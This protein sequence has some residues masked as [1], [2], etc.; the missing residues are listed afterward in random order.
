[1][2]TVVDAPYD[3]YLDTPNKSIRQNTPRKGVC[4]H[5][6]AMTSL[7]GLEYLTMGAK[8]VS[9]TAIAK[10][11]TS[12]RLMTDAYRAWSLSSA[13]GDSA[14]RSCECA[15]ESTNGWTISDASHWELAYLVAYWAQ[16]DGFWPHR[17]GDPKTWTVVGHREMYTIWGVSYATAC[18]GGMDLDLVT[19]RAQQILTGSGTAAVPE[20]K[21]DVARLRTTQN[22]TAVTIPDGQARRF[23][24][25]KGQPISITG[26]QN[27]RG[28]ITLHVYG[29]GLTE[30]KELDLLLIRG[31][32]NGAGGAESP[33]YTETIRGEAD[34]TFKRTV[35][36]AVDVPPGVVAVAEMRARGG[37]VRVNATGSEALL[38]EIE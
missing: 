8:Q 9:A 5:G 21:K 34:G 33:H 7:S 29:E 18:P 6:A 37:D 26:D 2:S 28:L 17:N 32:G 31:S 12:K 11:R 16:T 19:R 25:T 27:G 14:F 30:G 22:A 1:M 20:R 36:F 13:W 4:L 24:N 35:S 23:V 38:F 10:D 15:N 3:A